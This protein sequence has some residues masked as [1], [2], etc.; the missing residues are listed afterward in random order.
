MPGCAKGSQSSV[1]DYHAPSREHTA[2]TITS[3]SRGRVGSFAKVVV[4]LCERAHA[5]IGPAETELV[6]QQQW[7]RPLDPTRDVGAERVAK[8]CDADHAC[9]YSAVAERSERTC[10]RV[11]SARALRWRSLD[12]KW[13][14]TED[15]V[16]GHAFP[17][18][19]LI[20]RH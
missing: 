20:T 7:P 14:T 4:Y 13:F 12:K 2:R 18:F 6:L 8:H 15:L 10:S 11:G 9:M 16:Y 17:G 3:L 5:H 19:R 1:S